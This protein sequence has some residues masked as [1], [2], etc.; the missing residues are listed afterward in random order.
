MGNL[1]EV[2]LPNGTDIQYV[3]DGQ[4]RRVGKKV[5]GTPVEGFLYLNQ[6][7]PVAELDGSGNVVERFVYG[8]RSNVPDYIVKDGNIYRVI[9]DQLGSPR[10]I[11]NAST[12]VV[13]EQIDYDAWGN[14]TND[15][16]PG[17]Q[18]FGFAGGLYDQDTKLV[19]FGA[20]D[21][22]PETGRWTSKDPILFACGETSLYGYVGNDP[23]NATD[24]TGLWSV[25]VELYG[26]V[27]GGIVIGRD[28]ATGQWF[29][30]GRLGIGAGGGVSLDPMGKRPGVELMPCGG[31]TT[32]GT[33]IQASLTAGIFTYN[34]IQA[35]A[36]VDLRTG[37]QYK[38]GPAPAKTA[39]FTKV[40]FEIGGSFGVEVIG[41]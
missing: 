10:L 5:N 31:G 2:K 11:V 39:S 6:L 38:E 40:G 36:G 32:A 17:F 30:G 41:H 26:G 18:P 16:N 27:G 28:N 12:G 22:D 33:F 21:Y 3:I 37:D 13:A 34:P 14:V 19:R 24:E 25:T 8:S 1:L 23:V 20:R 35:A 15:T 4:N 29:Y 9:T 7:N